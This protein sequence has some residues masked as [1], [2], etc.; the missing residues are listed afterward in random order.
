[1]SQAIKKLQMDGVFPSRRK[2]DRELRRH[3]LALARPEAMATYRRLVR[4]R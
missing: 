1:V 4:Q 2:V 3:G